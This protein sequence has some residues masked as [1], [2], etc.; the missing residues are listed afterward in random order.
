MNGGVPPTAPN[1]RTGE[2]TPPGKARVARSNS[3]SDLP[4]SSLFLAVAAGDR[5]FQRWA[6]SADRVTYRAQAPAHLDQTARYGGEVASE[7]RLLQ[8]RKPVGGF[9]RVIGED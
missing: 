7:R 3:S 9:L 5:C 6:A 1:A 8:S 2:L 4:I